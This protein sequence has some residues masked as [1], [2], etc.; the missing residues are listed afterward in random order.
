MMIEL[1]EYDRDFI[2]KVLRYTH[3]TRIIEDFHQTS[4]H[5]DCAEMIICKLSV[6]DAKELVGQLSFEANHS[7]S[8]RVSEHADAI[9]ESIESQIRCDDGTE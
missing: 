8:K 6:C 5:P 2:I 4:A 9:A 3:L 7:R 1:Y